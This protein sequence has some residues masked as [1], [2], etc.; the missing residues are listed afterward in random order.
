MENRSEA[1]VEKRKHAHTSE[2]TNNVDH[3]I[4]NHLIF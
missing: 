1:G 3:I 2:G 4:N